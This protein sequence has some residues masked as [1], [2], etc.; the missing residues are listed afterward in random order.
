MVQ[1]T[2]E[3]VEKHSSTE[4]LI[5]ISYHGTHETI[6]TFIHDMVNGVTCRAVT[7]I[8]VPFQHE[9]RVSADTGINPISACYTQYIP[10]SL[11]L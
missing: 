7:M 5:K 8:Y 6:N 2:D 4:L 9:P 10:P 1:T 11:I 3:T